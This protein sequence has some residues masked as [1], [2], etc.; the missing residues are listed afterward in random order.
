MKTAIVTLVDD[1]YLPGTL[2]M[3]HSVR[4]TGYTGDVVAIVNGDLSRKNENIL[5]HMNIKVKV[6]DN[7][8]NP[9]KGKVT[10]SQIQ[11]FFQQANVYNK[12]HAWSLVEYDKVLFVD[13]DII[14]VRAFDHVW[15]VSCDKGW[16][17]GVEIPAVSDNFKQQ[18]GRLNT[19]V[20]LIVPDSDTYK[21][22]IDVKNLKSLDSY[23]H[24]DQ[25]YICT[26]FHKKIVFL[27]QDM[28]VSKRATDWE[29][30]NAR[31]IHFLNQPKPWN[32]PSRARIKGQ[33]FKLHTMW[34]RCYK[35]AVDK[36]CSGKQVPV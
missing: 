18:P 20:F 23:D 10:I 4:V 11:N 15:N 14:F 24:S 32:C 29:I 19:G 33:N 5:N 13:S 8:K 22:L 3:V 21:E 35:Q 16:I 36:L 17:A 25:G 26:Y 30:E 2:A 27:S 6:F 34:W 1:N 28:N 7:I 9:N 31:G 12:L